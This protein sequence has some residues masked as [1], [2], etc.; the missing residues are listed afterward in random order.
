MSQS[1]TLAALYPL[2]ARALE[3]ESVEELIRGRFDG[4]G[5][6]RKAERVRRCTLPNEEGWRTCK[7]RECCACAFRLSHRRGWEFAAQI[8]QMKHPVLVL[9]TLRSRS[10]DDLQE[11]IRALRR[12]LGV[13]LRKRVRGVRGALGMIEPKLS[14]DARFW[15]VHAHLVLDVDAVRWSDAAAGWHALSRGR[16]RFREDMRPVSSRSP[17]GLAKYIVKGS[18]ACPRPGA[19]PPSLLARLWVALFRVQLVVSL[20]VHV[21]RGRASRKRSP[22]DDV[23]YVKGA[24]RS[25]WKTGRESATRCRP[26]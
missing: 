6:R 2:E 21:R 25:R 11:T 20:G 26:T 14:D 16:G 8:R 10:L 3:L 12:L 19:L 13:F 15:A 9:A 18:D 7:Q 5:F 23:G 1:G 17:H 4:I 24:F 22:V